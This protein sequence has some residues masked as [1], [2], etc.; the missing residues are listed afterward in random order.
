MLIREGEEEEWINLGKTHQATFSNLRSG[1]YI[2]KVKGSN[3]DNVW[4][5]TGKT[6]YITVKAHFWKTRAANITYLVTFLLFVFYVYMYR[7]RSLRRMNREY[8][9]REIINAQIARQKD[10]LSIKNKNI[11]DSINYAKRIQEAMMPSRNIF[12]KL[13]PESFVLYKPKDIV[14]GDFYWINENN[15]KIFVAAVDCTGHGVPGAFMSIIGFELFRKITN[16]QGIEE[17]G[18]IMNMLNKSFGDIFRDVENFS[19]KDGMDIA[20][21]VIDKKKSIVEYAGAFNPL[22]IVRDDKISEV[23][24][25]RFSV[26]IDE[27][28]IHNQTFTNHMVGLEKEDVLYLFTDGYADQFGGQD[29]KK[30][31]YRRF[32]HLLL[33]IHKLPMEEQRELLDKTIEDWRGEFE[34]IDDI[35]VIGIKPYGNHK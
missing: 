1:N 13:L 35:L 34:Q 12:N 18:E 17:P 7:T 8:K 2:F 22:Y 4:N 11:T 32:R 10:E 9:E 5:E 27:E 6:L 31:K 29:G 25:D 3:S 14:S 15:G 16:I 28:L 23:K 26:G 19:L 21:C 20:F 33:N 24:G 30:F